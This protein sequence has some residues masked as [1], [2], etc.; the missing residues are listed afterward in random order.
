MIF[1]KSLFLK[2]SSAIIIFTAIGTIGHEL[3]HYF[4]AKFM[5]FEAR[6]SFASTRLLAGN[7]QIAKSDYLYFLLG[8]PFQTMTTGS[9]AFSLLLFYRK[10][11]QKFRNLNF[12]QWLLVFFSLFWLRQSAN[13]LIWIGRLILNGE[14]SLKPDEVKIAQLVG[15]PIWSL[16]SFTAVIG[17][18]I[19]GII[20]FRFIPKYQRST[21]LLSGII[22]AP[23][24]YYLWMSQL[25][26]KLL[27]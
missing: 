13:W 26:P 6:M 12:P 17:F 1:E 18:V 3:G 2:L 5:G 9:L 20:F 7:N 23:I 16:T 22:G 19:L 10:Q 15:L 8:G 14:P 24:G 25:G 11:F 21:F 4:T 27:A